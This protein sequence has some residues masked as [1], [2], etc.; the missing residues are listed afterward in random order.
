MALDGKSLCGSRDGESA[1]THVLGLFSTRLK[2][3]IGG[4]KVPKEGNEATA[5]LDLLDTLDLAGI[6]ITAD[7]MFCQPAIAR[8][9]IDK[10]GDY[11]LTVKGNKKRLK[12][13]IAQATAAEEAALSPCAFA[14]G[15]AGR[16]Q[17]RRDRR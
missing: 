8:K 3:L 5:A 1:C 17:N 7:A 9:I 2:G 12:Q 15:D 10:G 6:V 4:A 16:R 14:S 13:A 11:L